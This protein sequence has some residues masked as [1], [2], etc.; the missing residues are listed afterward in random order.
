MRYYGLIK[1]KSRRGKVACP[2][3]RV[4]CA[5]SL[6]RL[7]AHA[8][9]VHGDPEDRRPVALPADRAGRPDGDDPRLVTVLP[10]RRVVADGLACRGRGGGAGLD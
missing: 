7:D 8:V 6:R 4:A 10:G 1:K 3:H 2:R 5:H 9:P